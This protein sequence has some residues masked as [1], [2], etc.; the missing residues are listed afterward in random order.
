MS[1]TAPVLVGRAVN[2]L[3]LH[4]QTHGGIA[5]GAGQALLERC[6]YDPA[7]GQMLSA[8]FMDYALP[9]TDMFPPFV[10]EI[11]EALDVQPARPARRRR[12]RHH[13]GARRR[14][15]RGGGRAGGAG[16][17]AHRDAADAGARLAG[18]PR[19]PRPGVIRAWPCR[20]TLTG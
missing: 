4:G 14:R 17:R 5:A 13:A 11:S 12:G 3:I 15:Q 18:D 9:R 16:R 8:S 10:T 20:E 1:V 6:A 2:P 7:T 19:R